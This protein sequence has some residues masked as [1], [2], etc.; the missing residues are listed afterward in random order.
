MPE[1]SAPVIQLPFTDDLVKRASQ[2]YSKACFILYHYADPKHLE[3]VIASHRT[4]PNGSVD[5]KQKK[6]EDACLELC[7][8]LNDYHTDPQ[9]T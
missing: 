7:K 1:Q 9:T 3:A 8:A 6:I 5:P 2:A 4:L